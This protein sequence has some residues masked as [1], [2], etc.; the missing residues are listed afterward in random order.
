MVSVKKLNNHKY[1]MIVYGYVGPSN[2]SE[3]LMINE[4]LYFD[5]MYGFGG[6]YCEE[7]DVI[8]FYSKEEV[9]NAKEWIECVEVSAKLRRAK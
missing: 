5:M 9:N 1:L 7:K 4:E 6:K 2:V 8:F 3:Y